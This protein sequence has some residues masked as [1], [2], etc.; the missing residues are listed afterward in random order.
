[1]VGLCALG[2]GRSRIGQMSG[3]LRIQLS[4]SIRSNRTDFDC[5]VL[6]D[7][8]QNMPANCASHTIS[9]SVL[10]NE[11]RPQTRRHHPRNRPLRLQLR[12]ARHPADNWEG[13]L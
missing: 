8:L 10:Q 2:L 3:C 7:Y 11:T 5:Q 12:L 13:C 9:N 4:R 6:R 1:M